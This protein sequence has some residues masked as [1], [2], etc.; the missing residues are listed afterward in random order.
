MI[1]K[2]SEGKQMKASIIETSSSKTSKTQS[3]RPTVAGSK[4]KF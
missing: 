3:K 2:K 1:N 4:S